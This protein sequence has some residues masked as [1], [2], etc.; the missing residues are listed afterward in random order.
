[1]QLHGPP[2][3]P[4]GEM[5]SAPS[6]HQLCAPAAF[7]TPADK[8]TKVD[9]DNLQFP[10]Y[11]KV[12][13]GGDAQ[14][15]GAAC[16]GARARAQ[17]CLGSTLPTACTSLAS[18]GSRRASAET[19]YVPPALCRSTMCGC[20]RTPPPSTWAAPPSSTPPRSGWPGAHAAVA[21]APHPQPARPCCRLPALNSPPGARALRS[22]PARGR[23]GPACT[24][25]R[26][27][28]TSC[29]VHHR[30]PPPPPS[31]CAAATA[32]PTSSS[33]RI[34]CS[35]PTS[36]PTSPPAG[37]STGER[38]GPWSRF[39]AGGRA[40]GHGG[41][42]WAAE[43]RF[44]SLGPAAASHANAFPACAACPPIADQCPP[45][46]AP[47][48]PRPPHPAPQR[49]LRGPDPVLQERHQ[50]GVRQRLHPPGLL[51]DMRRLP[52][53]RRLHLG[54]PGRRQLEQHLRAQGVGAGPAVLPA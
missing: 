6:A 49:A 50:G 23:A 44:P 47:P 3:Q 35:S 54:A 26:H 24:P 25:R 53:V 51:P 14:E 30:C 5:S 45:H 37:P 41:P 32:T 2:A 28:L 22:P 13:R 11:Y 40:G 10:A 17:P 19:D 21:A 20:I 46:P 31:C 36:A 8:F 12:G 38:G 18:I 15:G 42:W 39:T 52:R 27:A 33:R 4:E 48:T 7:P 43:Q 16:C 34:R 9:I 29:A 1:M